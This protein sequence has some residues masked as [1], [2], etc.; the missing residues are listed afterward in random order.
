MKVGV[1]GLG[2]MGMGA[3]LSLVK[4]GHETWGCE[5]REGPRKELAAAGGHPVERAA[6]L[7][8]GLE[9]VVLLV[10]NAAQAEDVL[11]GDNGCIERLEPGTVVLGCVT[12]APAAS[13]ALAVRL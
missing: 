5:L 11:F 12:M 9:A 3:A 13:R 7:P 8:A 10:V 4:A 1:I 6:D 2:T